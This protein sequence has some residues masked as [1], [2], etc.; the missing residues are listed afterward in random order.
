MNIGLVEDKWSV[1][2]PR[3]QGFLPNSNFLNEVVEK[4]DLGEHVECDVDAERGEAPED[5]EEYDAAE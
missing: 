3:R 2:I 4:P 5:V 1:K